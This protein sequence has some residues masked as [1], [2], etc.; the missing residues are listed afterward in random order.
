MKLR[1]L[2]STALVGLAMVFMPALVWITAEGFYGDARF[3]MAVDYGYVV[4]PYILFM[5]LAALFSGVLNAT[6]RFAA[7]AAA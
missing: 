3:D 2:L 7:A 1:T 6:G 5:S 4:F